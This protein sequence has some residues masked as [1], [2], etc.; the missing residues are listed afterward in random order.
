MGLL[1]TCDYRLEIQEDTQFKK[2]TPTYCMLYNKYFQQSPLQV[3]SLRNSRMAV[4]HWPNAKLYTFNLP[5]TL[6]IIIWAEGSTLS[7]ASVQLSQGWA[8]TP[9]IVSLSSG[10]TFSSLQG[11]DEEGREYKLLDEGRMNEEVCR[12]M[13]WMRVERKGNTWRRKIRENNRDKQEK[14]VQ[15]MADLICFGYLVNF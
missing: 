3:N 9:S 13:V 15:Y 1:D 12:G 14:E 8:K 4:Q 7:R 2:G 6:S 5:L 11:A 10:F